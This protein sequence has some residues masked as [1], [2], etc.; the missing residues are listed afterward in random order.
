MSP[1]MVWSCPLLLV[2]LLILQHGHNVLL[3]DVD[4]VFSRLLPMRDLED[5]P[6]RIDVFHAYSTSYPTHV[7]ND[8]GFTV[9]GGMSWLRAT[10]PVLRFVGSVVNQCNCL[11]S[12]KVK[13]KKAAAATDQKKALTMPVKMQSPPL[14]MLLGAA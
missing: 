12:K 7:F 11:E 1:N 4:N 8:M 5:H 6:D 14:G 9:C 10:P 13:N 2:H 3:T